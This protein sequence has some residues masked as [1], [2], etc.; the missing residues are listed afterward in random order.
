MLQDMDK[1]AVATALCEIPKYLHEH[2]DT[3]LSARVREVLASRTGPVREADLIST[4][5]AQRDLVDSW[6]A[7]V[8]DQRTSD[9][10]YVE[11]SNGSA[12]QPEWILARPGHKERLAFDSPTAAYAALILRIVAQGLGVSQG[13]R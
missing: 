8:E 5:S 3:S 2:P 6:A 13:H 7:Y 4:L 12:R 9:G 11:V 1:A 10:W